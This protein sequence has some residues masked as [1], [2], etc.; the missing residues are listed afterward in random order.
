M[1]DILISP[2]EP[3]IIKQ[4][5]GESSSTPERYGVDIYAENDQGKK[6]GIQRKEVKDLIASMND[7]R[8]NKEVL[9][10]GELDYCML[11]VEGQLKWTNT[12]PA[13]LVHGY[14]SLYKP[15]FDG[16]L[17][18]IQGMGVYVHFTKDIYE[19]VQASR[20]WFKWASKPDHNSLF[21]RKE[22]ME[23]RSNWG[24]ID[25]KDHQAYFLTGINGIGIKIARR[26][27]DEVGLPFRLDK[28]KMDKIRGLK[29]IGKG[30]VEV[31]ERLFE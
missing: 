17:W 23:T 20:D 30:K 21:V 3:P 10:W 25:V 7:G 5:L 27:V 13:K 19:T 6:L 12:H 2:T 28:S 16:M 18:S 24:L 9:Q 1:L 11:I 31:I 29:G 15:A 4:Q 14:Q 22:K 8:L 26:I